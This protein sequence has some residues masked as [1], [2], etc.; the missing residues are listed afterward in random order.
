MAT[1]EWYERIRD[2]GG[3]LSGWCGCAEEWCPHCDERLP[4][5]W[6]GDFYM[7]EM[8]SSNESV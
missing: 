5:L 2:L 7:F 8:T 6:P 4:V 1:S 3:C